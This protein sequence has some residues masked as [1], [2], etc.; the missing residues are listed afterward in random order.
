MKWRHQPLER[1]SVLNSVYDNSVRVRTWVV[2]AIIVLLAAGFY[3]VQNSGRLHGGEIA[4]PKLIW[5]SYA[6]FFWYCLP[7]LLILD[8]RIGAGW[9][10]IYSVFL[11]NM[12]I[13]AVIELIMMY[14][15]RNWSPYYG[16]AHDV[17]SIALLAGLLLVYRNH[18]KTDIFFG[19]V[20]IVLL[21]FLVEIAFVLY[22]LANVI[23]SGSAVYFVPDGDGHGFILG[24]TWLVVF[25]LTAYLFMFT[26]RWFRGRFVRTGS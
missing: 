3:T 19:F 23:E 4:L 18:V 21:M 2:L 8:K 1:K 20:V 7:L 10:T 25:V 17:F 11:V 26:R 14:T 6:I 9:R 12:L 15:Y 24:V 13:R 22:M 16:I 5:L